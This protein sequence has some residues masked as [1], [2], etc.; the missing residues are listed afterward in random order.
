MKEIKSKFSLRHAF[1]GIGSQERGLTNGMN[2]F[3]VCPARTSKKVHVSRAHCSGT[4]V[5]VLAGKLTS[6]VGSQSSFHHGQANINVS[7]PA[8]NAP[9]SL[10]TRVALARPN[11]LR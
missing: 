5:S 1:L 8:T 2:E 9:N 4:K 11:I 3:Q 7:I 10:E 6:V